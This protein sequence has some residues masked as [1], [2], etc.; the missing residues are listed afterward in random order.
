MESDE[1]SEIR[2]FSS[3]SKKSNCEQ[4]R[5]KTEPAVDKPESA[6]NSEPAVEKTESASCSEPAVQKTESNSEPTVDKLESDYEPAGKKRKRD[7]LT[8]S[9]TLE[10]E[11]DYPTKDLEEND[12]II[13]S[14]SDGDDKVEG[15]VEDEK[16][17]GKEEEEEEEKRE[18]TEQSES[19]LGLDQLGL[20]SWWVRFPANVIYNSC[21]SVALCVMC[22]LCRSNIR[23][24][25][26]ILFRPPSE[27]DSICTRK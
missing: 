9:D 13:S 6:L 1:E 17:R 5:K 20:N 10:A 11:G 18:D 14:G 12:Q 3:K 22:V 26:T 21:P 25:D 27:H 24:V 23:Q 19:K 7:S 4:A 8:V 15:E 16:Q 2:L